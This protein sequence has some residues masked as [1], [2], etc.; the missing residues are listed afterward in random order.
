[1]QYIKTATI[2][3]FLLGSLCL[4]LSAQQALEERVSEILVR[5]DRAPLDGAWG[6][7]FELRELPGSKT[8][9]AGAI[10]AAADELGVVG[11][12]T[13]ARSLAGLS[14]DNSLGASILEL[15][16]PAFEATGSDARAAAL[17][18]LGNPRLFD[19]DQREEARS[20]LVATMDSD[21]VSPGLRLE[22]ARSLLTI[23]SSAEQY[24]ARLTLRGLLGG[25]DLTLRNQSALALVAGSELGTELESWAILE[26]IADI[27]SDEGREAAVL[28]ERRGRVESYLQEVDRLSEKMKE[29]QNIPPFGLDLLQ[30]IVREI[31]AKHPRATYLN[32]EELVENSAKALMRSLDRHSAFFTSDEF[33]RFYFDL[34]REYGGIGAYV[35]FDEDGIFSIVRPIYS[36]PA[37][38]VGLRSGDRI[39][40]VDGW[41]TKG[42]DIDEI[43]GNLK[44]KPETQVI[45]QVQRP[46]TNEIEDVSVMREQIR[47]PSINL[48]MLPGQIGYMELVVFASST[49]QEMSK[50]I[51]ELR[52]QGAT[53]LI[54]DLRNNTGGFLPAARDVVEQFVKGKKLVVYTQGRR[55]DD[56]EDLHTR[57]GE[58]SAPDMPLAVLINN[59][60]ASASEIAAGALQDYGR[61]TVVG[62]RSFG[63]GSVQGL[64]G[65]STRPPE[66][67]E[68]ENRNGQRDD[69]EKFEDKNGN[70]K[71]DVG[72]HIKLTVARYHLPSGRSL[73]KEIDADGKILNEDWGVTPDAEIEMIGVT[74]KD[75]F[76]SN[77]LVRLLRDKAFSTYVDERL[78]DYQDLF[79]ELAEAD[80]GSYERYP[81]FEDYYQS[82][83]TSL[84]REDL[85]R[86]IRYFLREKIPDIRGKIYPGRRALGDFQEDSQLQEAMRILLE[87][88][89]GDI[90]KLPELEGLLE[91]TFDETET[92]AKAKKV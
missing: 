68:D 51:Q 43:I 33:Q 45:L 19:A 86:W 63:K 76:E 88:Q 39:L 66:V 74:P 20:I 24:R 2:V 27:P 9:I 57:N 56:R 69:W 72:P 54:L 17:G 65:L 10:R 55:A 89:G 62:Q 75:A 12:L 5:A 48:E 8:E 71:Y 31:R 30:E 49:G 60:S 15:L 50:A 61:A 92:T 6:F 90:R 46:G 35:N 67:Y 52:A 85:R 26:R 23:G 37:Y 79:L 29:D 22:S 21:S 53:S 80:A 41:D 25:E 13:A 38:R 84:S 78:D 11:R 14:E 58:A 82:L 64:L 59:F 44:G 16:K 40:K 87:K 1:M 34:D 70:H 32:N 47:V 77:E 4:Q 83:E 18:I 81:D 28:V 42:H 91:L 36:G 7:S 3:P 73:H